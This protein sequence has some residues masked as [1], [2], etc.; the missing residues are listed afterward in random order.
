MV[1]RRKSAVEMEMNNEIQRR[2]LLPCHH[3]IFSHFFS[4]SFVMDL[5][6]IGRM[7]G[8]ASLEIIGLLGG[9]LD[10]NFDGQDR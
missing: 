5:T 4:I 10:N 3:I 6:G 2:R 7:I 1:I 8:Q 9:G